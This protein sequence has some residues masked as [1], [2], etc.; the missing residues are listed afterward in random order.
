MYYTLINLKINRGKME[1][2]R[3]KDAKLQGLKH[4]FT[5][6]PCNRGHIDKRLV[7]STTCCTCIRENHYTYYDNHRDTAL[8]GIK[9]WSQNN[10]Q[11]VVDTSRRYRANNPNAD[12]TNSK[13][14]YSKPE[15]SKNHLQY[16][17]WWRS[18]NKEK[19]QYYN[20]VR[21]A[22][23]K[24]AMP[25]WANV[26]EILK[27][28]KQSVKITK[29]TGI[30]HHVDHIIPLVNDLVCGLHVHENLQILVATHNMEKNNKFIID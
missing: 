9:R 5:G 29:E 6:V 20:S 3:R 27:I 21:R 26:E 7:S 23:I 14:W 12:S 24:Q 28:Y 2:I 1:I 30:P 10:K 22:R 17:K 25:I 19:L 15:N 4:Y 18:V 11:N 16:T 8:A 13:K